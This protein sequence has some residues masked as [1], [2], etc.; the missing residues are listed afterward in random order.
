MSSTAEL[1][2]GL[3]LQ[4]VRQFDLIRKRPDFDNRV[5]IVWTRAELSEHLEEQI[6]HYCLRRL[7]PDQVSI[8]FAV[9]ANQRMDLRVSATAEDVDASDAGPADSGGLAADTQV[10]SVT[11]GTEALGFAI[12]PSESWSPFG[13][14]DTVAA[15]T[16]PGVY[17][18]AASSVVPRGELLVYRFHRGVLTLTRTRDRADADAPGAGP[19]TVHVDGRAL[20]PGDDVTMTSDSSLDLVY[21]GRGGASALRLEL[22]PA[23]ST[24]LFNGSVPNPLPGHQLLVPGP[25]SAVIA[26][27]PPARTSRIKLAEFPIAATTVRRGDSGRLHAQVL[28]CTGVDDRGAGW[29]VKIYRCLTAAHA[30]IV[31]RILTTQADLAEEARIISHSP[32]IVEV[33]I[34]E[35]GVPTGAALE[36]T[37]APQ[38][39]HRDEPVDVDVL[40]ASWFG[41]PSGPGVD[42][43]AVALSPLLKTVTFPSVRDNPAPVL[44]QLAYLAPLARGLDD[45]HRAGVAHGDIK[46]DNLCRRGPEDSSYI[47][48]DIDSVSR[49][50]AAVPTHRTTWE[51]AAPTLLE[52]RFGPTGSDA[53]PIRTSDRFAFALLVVAAVADSRR[54]DELVVR[55]PQAKSVV[56]AVQ[57]ARQAVQSFW[58]PEWS[59]FAGVL[60]EG[61]DER[62]ILDDNLRLAE[63]I[64]RLAST[65]PGPGK[66][67]AIGPPI[68]EAELV[69]PVELTR[70]HRAV[71]NHSKADVDE[72]LRTELREMRLELARR[73]YRQY[74]AARLTAL[75]GVTL[76]ILFFFVVK[77]VF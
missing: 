4:A 59:R 32:A 21:E 36:T 37:V 19:V 25:G 75:V 41:I 28:I 2:E 39:E 58:G 49:I 12:E 13:R 67:G 60:A 63:W 29:H 48:V 34:A 20:V 31:R 18:P 65:G 10:L 56:D 55:R 62:K 64:E 38:P 54:R 53:V 52:Q 15:Q 77:V 68:P 57:T 40:L 22:T 8:R 51:Y 43:Y 46:A 14:F 3:W 45:C 27:D 47:L 30:R 66:R 61:F 24:D 76:L 11:V 35:I 69:H 50:D 73:A 1:E 44:D 33:R 72:A 9:R 17:L 70:L 7:G 23:Y 42:C 16:R 6:S 71:Q 26:V 5:V 74:L